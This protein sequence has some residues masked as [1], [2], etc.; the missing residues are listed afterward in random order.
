MTT[1]NVSQRKAV[2]AELAKYCHLSG[3]HDYMEVT[4]WSNGEGA[5]ISISRKNAEE[6]FSLTYGEFELLMVLMN[7][8]GE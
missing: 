3:A 2:F 1:I 7:W 4:E 6:K 8:K 5:D